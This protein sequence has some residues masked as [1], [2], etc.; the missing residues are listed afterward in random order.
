MEGIF[1]KHMCCA[2]VPLKAFIILMGFIDFFIAILDI[3]SIYS[4]ATYISLEDNANQRIA[5]TLAVVFFSIRLLLFIP[6]TFYTIKLL[7]YTSKTG[8]KILYGLKLS[9]FILFMIF[10]VIGLG[11]LTEN[12]CTVMHTKMPNF[13]INE[14]IKRI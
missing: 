14:R 3:F 8:G 10:N 4:R 2:A 5:L 6:T 7:F 1:L 9:V 12:G 13:Q 11:F